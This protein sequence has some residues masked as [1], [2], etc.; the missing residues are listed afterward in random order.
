M[1]N[2]QRKSRITWKVPAAYILSY[3]GKIKL[4]IQKIIMN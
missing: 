2:Q 1:N 3:A 4:T